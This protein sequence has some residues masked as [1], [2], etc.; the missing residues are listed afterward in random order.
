MDEL[1][2]AG[3]L[4]PVLRASYAECKRLNA[5]HG[6]TY[7]LATLLLP[8]AKRPFVHALYGFARYADEIVDDLSSQHD[9]GARSDQLHKWSQA[10]LASLKNGRSDDPLGMALIDTA[11][12]FEIPHK[13]FEAFLNSMTMD[14]CIKEYD[15]F[16]QL[17]EYMYGSAAVIGLEMT[18]VLGA[19]SSDA[20]ESAKKLGIAFQLTNFIRDVSE[21]LDRGRI[22]L[23]LDELKLHGVKREMLE[24]KVLTPE[25]VAA[26]KDQISRV[27]SL[28]EEARNGILLLPEESRPGILAAT[29]MYC[30]I[31]DAVE[32]NN[33]NIFTSRARVPGSRKAKI[34]LRA[35]AQKAF[36]H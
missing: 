21:D 23:P 31:V 12:R 3:I 2:S 18:H 9:R 1:T 34:M 15:T 11:S 6:K 30:G 4:D 36:A 13:Y 27:R 19:K 14:L 26:L 28:Q 25:I 20:L 33:Y 8:K 35:Y 32:A 10:M 22:Y 29:E 16:D 5:E 17:M 7:F 24:R